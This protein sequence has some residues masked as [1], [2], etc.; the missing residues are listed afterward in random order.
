LQK[1]I[2]GVNKTTNKYHSAFK[3][4]KKFYSTQQNSNEGIDI[5]I[6]RFENAK[7]LVCLFNANVVDISFL[8]IDEQL[9]DATATAK[10]PCKSILPSL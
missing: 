8:L 4:N 1:I 6:D 5:F 2:A 9:T 3:A 10:Q 7:D